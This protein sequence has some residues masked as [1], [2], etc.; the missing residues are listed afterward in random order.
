MVLSHSLPS[1]FMG[2]LVF[3]AKNPVYTS[4]SNA[5]PPTL[6]WQGGLDQ[7]PG[8]GGN[9]LSSE[10]FDGDTRHL[11]RSRH[12]NPGG[13]HYEEALAGRDFIFEITDDLTITN[14]AILGGFEGYVNVFPPVDG[15]ETWADNPVGMQGAGSNFSLNTWQLN[16]FGP[17]V[18]AGVKVGKDFPFIFGTEFLGTSAAYSTN[19]GAGTLAA[20]F[21]GVLRW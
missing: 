16:V 19:A 6:Y 1:G 4:Y 10:F 14:N 17:A 9:S 15:Y 5:Q 2:A 18:S 11:Y 8:A 3:T 12:F 21:R 13:Y 20:N 7:V